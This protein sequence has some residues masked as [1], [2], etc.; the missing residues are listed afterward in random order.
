MCRRSRS[1]GGRSIVTS[2]TLRLPLPGPMLPSNGGTDDPN[3]DGG[4]CVL[5]L[6]GV[7]VP[8]ACSADD[9]SLTGAW[10]RGRGRSL[11]RGPNV[12]AARERSVRSGAAR[13]A[14]DRRPE[15]AAVP[16]RRRRERG[17]GRRGER[18]K[19]LGRRAVIAPS[20]D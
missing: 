19:S 4:V 15:V 5:S 1:T 7:P 16:R 14:A 18:A 6:G 12:P 11:R 20:G 2:G 17:G 13:L 9:L 3:V 10:D 8:G